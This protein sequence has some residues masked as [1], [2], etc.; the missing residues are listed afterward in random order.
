MGNFWEMGLS[1]VFFFFFLKAH[2]YHNELNWMFSSPL[3]YFILN[4]NTHCGPGNKCS[5]KGGNIY[6]IQ[7]LFQSQPGRCL[8]CLGNSLVMFSS[9]FKLAQEDVCIAK[10]GESPPLRCLVSKFLGNGKALK[11]HTCATHQK[12]AA[13]SNIP[14]YITSFIKSCGSTKGSKCFSS[15][16]PTCIA[17]PRRLLD[18]E[19]SVHM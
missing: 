14:P 5:K 8:H 4:Y 9:Y 13:T 15:T 18:V 16:H 2:R 19:T 11:Q 1:A 17:R 10:I 12:R 3:F 6:N 7:Q